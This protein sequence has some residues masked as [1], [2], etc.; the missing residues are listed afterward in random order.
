MGWGCFR[1]FY[2]KKKQ[3][4]TCAIAAFDIQSSSSVPA[5]LPVS[6]REGRTKRW[7]KTSLG[8]RAQ[9]AALP[10][11]LF[12]QLHNVR[13]ITRERKRRIW[14]SG[15]IKRHKSLPGP[16]PPLSSLSLQ[17][18]WESSWLC[19]VPVPLNNITR[20]LNVFLIEPGQFVI[21]CCSPG[22]C[23]KI[24]VVLSEFYQLS[25]SEEFGLQTLPRLRGCGAAAPVKQTNMT[26]AQPP[27][28]AGR[29]F[30]FLSPEL[31]PWR[32][33]AGKWEVPVPGESVRAG[34]CL[35][36]SQGCSPFQPTSLPRLPVM[37]SSKH[38]QGRSQG[39][40]HREL[41]CFISNR[42]FSLAPRKLGF[43]SPALTREHIASSAGC[44][45]PAAQ[46]QKHISSWKKAQE[47]DSP[48]VMPCQ[49]Q[50]VLAVMAAA[51]GRA[52]GWAHTSSVLPFLPK[53]NFQTVLKMD[54]MQNIRDCSQAFP[55]VLQADQ[56]CLPSGNYLMAGTEAAAQMSLVSG[57]SVDSTPP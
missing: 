56:S 18:S 10:F 48:P 30:T 43:L 38:A 32:S 28:P 20:C 31:I 46:T 45:T 26:P 7:T 29:G 6:P 37:F 14:L 21:I 16:F 44:L 5:R 34:S 40:F 8:C 23:R 41:F 54:Q 47:L 12:S 53:R 36:M 35:G 39:K 25:A 17:D 9:S 15:E 51:P 2:R 33:K 42:N 57:T 27:S 24:P 50:E 55:P 52:Q 4:T 49:Q 13:G 3:K 19:L 11:P 1:C 22:G